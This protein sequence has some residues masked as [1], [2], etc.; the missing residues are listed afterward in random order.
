MQTNPPVIPGDLPPLK[1]LE[2]PQGRQIAYRHRPGTGPLIVYL[3][4]YASDMM[5]TK[6]QFLDLRCAAR[7]QG[8]LRFDCSGNGNSR[9]DLSE[10]TIGRWIED[11]LAVID[12]VAAGPVILVGSSMGGW[13]GLHC[14]LK[15]PEKVRAFIGIAAAPDFTSEILDSMTEA[16]KDLCAQRGYHE[17]PTSLET[18][19]RIY[20]GLLDDGT[21]QCLL[22]G[23]INL[24][25]PVVLMQGRLDKEVPWATAERIKNAIK[26]AIT[27]IIYI[28]DGDHR[29]AL[30]DD[31]LQ[32]DSVIER[33][34]RQV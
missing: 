12:T 33:L 21:A 24:D 16:D 8:F 13:I 5:A 3:H 10:G 32:I 25:I 2:T 17:L 11:T 28:E 4:G 1:M 22:K 26:P 19:L 27:E 6:A 15:R 30:P 9:G 20:K 7:G 18:P 14:A 34:S 23:P 29:L 31:M